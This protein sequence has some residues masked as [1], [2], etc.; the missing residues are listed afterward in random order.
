MEVYDSIRGV[1]RISAVRSSVW[2]TDQT[3]ND[4]EAKD[5]NL[6]YG[7]YVADFDSHWPR[8]GVQLADECS[9]D[10]G[11]EFLQA[12]VNRCISKGSSE[13]DCCGV[14]NCSQQSQSPC[15]FT[16]LAED[17]SIVVWA[18]GD[19]EY[20]GKDVGKKLLRVFPDSI[21]L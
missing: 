20:T 21:N 17:Q 1:D 11:K 16:L 4:Y 9:D 5:S 2:D 12:R 10:Y 13:Y 7:D 14:S 18:T 3:D 6:E 19:D 15:F 8:E